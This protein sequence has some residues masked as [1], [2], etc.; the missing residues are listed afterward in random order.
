M[1]GMMDALLGGRGC[2]VDGTMTRNPITAMADRVFESHLALGPQ[3]MNGVQQPLAENPSFFIDDSA[4]ST[5]GVV[6]VMG[7]PL[8]R[9]NVTVVIMF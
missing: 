6:P 9:Y 2:S 1:D 4:H 8:V 3:A 5:T 7:N